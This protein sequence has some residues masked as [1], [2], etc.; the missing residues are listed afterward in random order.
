MRSLCVCAAWCAL[1]AAWLPAAALLG[2]E[3][4]P[5]DAAAAAAAAPLA[6]GDPALLGAVVESLRPE[7]RQELGQMLKSDWRDRPEWGDML[8]ALLVGEE[9]GPRFGWYKPSEK[10]HDWSWLSS[11]FDFNADGPVT[12]DELPSDVPYADLLYGRLDRDADGVLRL[13]DFDYSGMQQTTPPQYLSRFVTSVLDADSNGRITPEELAALLSRLDQEEIG[14]LTSDD[15][16]R[17][18]TRAFDELNSGDEDMPTP[19]E[20]LSMFFRG[21][22]GVWDAGPQ[23]GEV[24]PDFSL[25]T[26]DGGRTVTLSESRGKPV[27][28]IFGSFT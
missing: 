14:F 6:I 9:M 8:V 25:P 27:V 3:A 13:G 12:R 17:D 7:G 5:P 21:E 28:L 18:F 11:K 16:L 22:L 20:M 23:L 26:H 19:D 2:Q 1:L 15:L 24:A 10:K 4:P